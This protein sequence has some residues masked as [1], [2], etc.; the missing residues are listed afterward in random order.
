[1]DREEPIERIVPCGASEGGLVIRPATRRLQDIPMPPPCKL[2][3]D[4]VALLVEDR[5]DRVP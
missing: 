4:P 2:V 1:M 5:A 3:S